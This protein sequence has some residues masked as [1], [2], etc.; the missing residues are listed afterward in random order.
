MNIS[1]YFTS[2]SLGRRLFFFLMALFLVSGLVF[3]QAPGPAFGLR[4]EDPTEP[5]PIGVGD[6]PP[7][8]KAPAEGFAWSMEKRFGLDQDGDGMI[9][10]HWITDPNDSGKKIYEPSYVY[11]SSWKVTF[12]GCQSEY[13]HNNP[14]SPAHTYAWWLD[15][16]L[17]PG[18][19]CKFPK[20]YTDQEPH[21]ARL[22]VLDENFEP[23]TFPNGQ[24]YIEQPVQI[25]DYFIVSM[26]DSLASGEG[27]PDI[28]QTY[29]SGPGGIFWVLT[30]PAKWQ[31]KRCHRSAISNAALAALA[32]EAADPHTSVTFISFACSGATIN[33]PM[34]EGGDAAKPL[35]TGILGPYRGAETDVPFSNNNVG[36][37]PAQIDQLQT[38]LANRP[39]GRSERR[40]DALIISAGGNDIH[41]GDVVT[42]CIW[43]G[44]CWSNSRVKEDPNSNIEY[45]LFELVARA[46]KINIVN[47]EPS[48]SPT[49]V[50]DGLD[51]LAGRIN[52]LSPE[53][54]AHIYLTQYMDQTR[55][56]NGNAC[57]ML[58]DIG[59][60]ADKAIV[61]SES[62]VASWYATRGLNNVLK[63][64]ADRHKD[65]NWQFVDGISS[66][67]V[68][69]GIEPGTPG[70]FVRDGNGRGHGYCASDNWIRRADES[71][72]IQG[73]LWWRPGSR[74]TLHP[75]FSGQQVIK[76][77]ILYYMLPDL[78][79]NMPGQAPTFSFSFS[80]AGLTSQP[81]ANGWFIQSCDSQEVCF[82]KVM[83]QAVAVSNTAMNGA[84]IL[85]NDGDGCT[86]GVACSITLSA[87]EKQ[88]TYAVEISASG[89]YRFQFNAQDSNG[90]VSFLQR[91]IKVDL[92][93]P[94]LA[95]PIGPFEVDE[96]GSVVV[97]ATMAT[98]PDGVVMN[99]DVVVNYDWDLNDDGIFETTD[100]QPTFSAEELN[101]PSSQTIQVH[102]TDRAGRTATAQAT[103]NVLNVAP[104]PVING[105]PASSN[106]GTAINLTSTVIGAAPGDLYT[107]A[108]A[109]K[110]DGSSYASGTNA[111][112][113]FTPDDNASYEVSLIVTDDNG[114]EGTA[115]SQT[116]T[117]TNVAP[118]LSNLSVPSTSVNEG[119]S[120]TFSGDITEP[121]TADTLT[122]TID[123]GDGSADILS[124]S[125]GSTSFSRSHTYADDNPTGTA[126]DTYQITLSVTDD[127]AGTG[128]GSV[129]MVVNNLAPSLSISAPE[130][131]SL[132][133]VKAMVNLSASLTDPSRFDTLT[134]SVNW[135]DGATGSGT[136]AAG[137][138]TASHVYTAAGVYTI[139]M[140]GMDD[141]TGA[142]I[143]SVMV[144]VYDPSAGFVTGGG[145][146]N[147]PT[148]AYKVDESLTG[149]ATFGF[150]SK[151]QK[152]ANI[153]TGITAFEFDLAGLAFSSTSYEWLVVNQSGTNAQF[154]GTG[155]ING[156]ADPN[157]NA[158]KFML[159][160]GDGSPDTFRIRIWWE[161]AA[162]EQVVYD[163]GVDQ[164]I[165]AGNIVVHT[166]K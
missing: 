87:D 68:Q 85:V 67:E 66:Y 107:Y 60:W 83:V 69:P 21:T 39:A 4:R 91:E 88:L 27:D 26:G 142:K 30:E 70:L 34:F 153:P 79:D 54:P 31:D 139:Q 56:D 89:I 90:R 48:N 15:N 62:E 52:E 33:T 11:P 112:F 42:K 92:E 86:G 118:A 108:W 145:W 9:D 158:Y 117:V 1:K 111:D 98:T 29:I 109:V 99:D 149:K 161:D 81:G 156:V 75:N 28:P 18:N 7:P 122:L 155:Q 154:K 25:K 129:S 101:G 121:G 36:Y 82:P 103:V 124:L 43:D 37:I 152:G 19:K 51:S 61:P 23:I 71:E 47:G 127:D 148:G 146:I 143:E 123:W 32:L 5:D 147:S 138:C 73:P 84:S 10:Y 74:G 63:A 128:T 125:A 46:L 164:T 38:A 2:K 120:F 133:A 40:I 95:T 134:C 80:S 100:E 55:D 131:G 114:D 151:Y 97:S 160:A 14:T 141:D 59:G 163:N 132:Y 35:G 13:D 130:S 53:P 119:A 105:A 137:A 116:I 49:N 20:I 136:L 17:Q 162:G 65:K 104:D 44:D 126:S 106:E 77:R 57:L 166:G 135:D 45:G 113:S 6:D 102:V 24:T 94:V 58:E 110:K 3:T 76:S 96:G 159:W 12:D 72:L 93:D 144:V 16:V 78:L 150:V 140:T 157:G 115:P 50:P 64:A 165:G 22:E 8:Y 41:F